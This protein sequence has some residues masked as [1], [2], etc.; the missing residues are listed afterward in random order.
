MVVLPLENATGDSDLDYLAEGIALSTTQRLATVRGLVL[1]PGTGAPAGARADPRAAA[2][3]LG[4]FAALSWSLTVAD[5]GLAVRAELRRTS[6]GSRLWHCECPVRLP[7]LHGIEETIVRGVLGQ[8][9]PSNPSGRLPPAAQTSRAP[10]T[11]ILQL[12]ARHYWSQRTASGYW[13]ALGLLQRSIDEDPGNAEAYAWLSA[14]F[15]AM[16]VYGYL[17]PHETFRRAEAA[18]ERA[19]ELDAGLADAHNALG[20]L[21]ALYYWDWSGAETELR[22]ALEL[23]SEFAESHNVLAHVYRANG[24]YEAALAEA[25]VAARLDPLEPYYGHHVGILLFCSGREQEAIDHL[26]RAMQFSTAPPI[27]RQA[28]VA[29]WARLG[30]PDSAVAAWH[31]A[32]VAAGDSIEASLVDANRGLGLEATLRAA[33]RADLAAL[34]AAERE[35]Q[36]LAPM[37]WA[38]A[39]ARAG[40][41]AEAMEAVLRGVAERDPQVLY[42]RCDPAFDPLRDDPRLEEAA[43]RIGLP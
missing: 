42:L 27:A 9:R 4:G 2:Q 24:R 20:A 16:A 38:R 19:L 11:R 6:D 39:H 41:R 12:K 21:R 18:A 37:R 43:R 33:G 17:A 10:E 31:A 34:R 32:A 13:K 25:R 35:G 22:R 3:A 36:F 5:S 1:V 23:N 26:R 8:V 15:G 28:L 7:D 14:T 30:R 40:D 29:A